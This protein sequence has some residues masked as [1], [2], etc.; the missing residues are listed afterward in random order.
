MKNINNKIS[1]SVWA[2]IRDP[3][4]KK[5]TRSVDYSVKSDVRNYVWF[6][7]SKQLITIFTP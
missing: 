5:I 6:V 4:N 3:Y 7:I 1:S 2:V